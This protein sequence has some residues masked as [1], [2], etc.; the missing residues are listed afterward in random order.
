MITFPFLV[1]V[2]A[3]VAVLGPGLINMYIAVGVVGWVFYA[4]LLRAEI[5]VQKQQRLRGRRAGAGLW[6]RAYHLPPPAAQRG[7]ADAWSTG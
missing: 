3:I 5:R 4:R 7:H 2:I 1:L 6:R